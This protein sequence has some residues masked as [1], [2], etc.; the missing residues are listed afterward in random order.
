[1]ELS[2]LE[3]QRRE[4]LQKLRDMGIEPYPAELFP[5][6]DYAKDLKENFVEDKK[7]IIAG[8]MMSQRVMGKA[9]FA[10]ILDSTGRIQTYFNRDELCPGEDKS[11][12]NDVFKK[13]LD[14]GDFIGIEG[15][16]FKTQVGEIS[17]HV[18]SFKLLSKSL[19]PLPLPKPDAEGKVHDA[20]V[21]PEL[22]YRQR[23][24]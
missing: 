4:S 21:A 8:R 13:L 23:Y 17:V 15:R 1:M 5:V 7:V 9:S 14:L 20:V 10:E 22:R 16:L 24:G 3:I 19:K 18:D 11:M 6:S 2:A 12:Y